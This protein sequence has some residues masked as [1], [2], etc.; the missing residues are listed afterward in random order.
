MVGL[1]GIDS[2]LGVKTTEHKAFKITASPK[3]HQ[4]F[5]DNG[6]QQE[7]RESASRKKSS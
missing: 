7:Q 4:L 2:H 3:G 6:V 5:A 1:D